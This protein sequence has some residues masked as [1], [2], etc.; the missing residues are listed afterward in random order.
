MCNVVPHPVFWGPQVG[1]I[2]QADN[3]NM[4]YKEALLCQGVQI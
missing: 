1:V 3:N 2:R 4:L